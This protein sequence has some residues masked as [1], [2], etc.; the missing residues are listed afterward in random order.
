MEG[1]RSLRSKLGGIKRRPGLTISPERNI[2]RV[3]TDGER[4]EQ[5]S[6]HQCVK[7]SKKK[8]NS[9]D[10]FGEGFHMKIDKGHSIMT[11]SVGSVLS[12][13]VF[14]IMGSYTIQKT[15]ILIARTDDHVMTSIQDSYFEPDFKFDYGMGLN[16]A[17]A[18][19]GFESE[20]DKVLTPDIG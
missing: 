11:T 17:I 3:S 4:A 6:L 1:S 2:T 8:F 12:I 13:I 9:L 15:N 10:R 5:S 19:T 18:F 7:Y 16:A 20:N 14:I